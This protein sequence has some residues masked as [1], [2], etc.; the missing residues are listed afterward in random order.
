M[1]N[2]IVRIGTI[3]SNLDGIEPI[4]IPALFP[5]PR[6]TS[7]LIKASG[8][9]KDIAIAGVQ[10]LLLQ[11]LIAVPP[12]NLRFTFFDPLGLGQNI[13]SF[14]N[15]TEYDEM[16][17]NSRAWTEV[18]HIEQRLI[19]ISEHMENVIQ[20]YLR[21]EFATISEYNANAHE[22]AE[23]Y[24]ILVV[25][26]F[27]AN[28][29]EE[30]TRRLLSIAQNGPRCGVYAVIL[31][32]TEKELP[33]GVSLQELERV[34][35]VIEWRDTDFVWKDDLYKNF[36]LRLDTP[37]DNRLFN[38]ILYAVGEEARK[39]KEVKVPFSRIAPERENGQKKEQQKEKEPGIESCFS[40]PIGP[41]GARD[42]QKLE[43]GLG[44]GIHALVVGRTG[45]GKS[46][47]LHTI[48]VSLALKY[49]PDDAEL[50]LIDFKKG[51]EFKIYAEHKLPHARVIAIESEREFG[52][53]VLQGLDAEMQ[54]RG[55]LFRDNGVDSL[56]DYRTKVDRK[57][58]RILLLVDEFQEFFAEDDTVASQASQLLDRLVRQ[59]RA[60]GIHIL[61][62]SQTLAGAYA[63]SRS[64]IDQMSVRIALQC[65]D[66]DSRLILAD[67]NPA[68]RLL[69]R[70]GEA[71]YNSANGMIEGNNRFQ[72][73]WLPEEERNQYLE[74][75][76]HTDKSEE[77]LQIVFEGNIPAKL[78][79]NDIL[80]NLLKNGSPTTPQYPLRAYLGEPVAIS[81]PVS[82]NFRRQSGCN[83]LFVGRN[84]EEA[85]G[86]L[87]S[88]IVSLFAQLPLEDVT[89]DTDSVNTT[90]Y[91][92]D[93]TP[94]D[95]PDARFFKDVATSIPHTVK[96]GRRN[97]LQE[98]LTELETETQRR[99]DADEM[100]APAVFLLIFGLQ[101]ARDLRQ[102]NSFSPYTPEESEDTSPNPL[103][104]FETI[105]RD[106]PEVGVHTL[107]WCDTATNVSRSL[108]HDIMREFAMRVVM[109]MN[110]DDSSTLIDSPMASKLGAHRALFYDDEEIRL[111][112]L[113]PY[114][115]PSIEWLGKMKSV[116]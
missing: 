110:A 61:L 74:R 60:F 7:L 59:G 69:S 101:R 29:N 22:I 88:S 55:D 96:T 62:G 5:F 39:N 108:N 2:S 79:N 30:T 92:L 109:Q 34:T 8:D 86:M 18:R 11:L 115:T 75:I 41:K 46:T 56:Q 93:F 116:L 102:E 47:L 15:L 71:I 103:K 58:P 12:G 89:E 99:I 33:H 67:D 90:F 106:G 57:M 40:I 65:S 4:S 114:V 44:T 76:R 35:S 83:L 19:D 87:T 50:Y 68:A 97:Q 77:R 95:S 38:N 52:L 37:P 81:D 26:D 10:S 27:P 104:Q 20:K 25:F 64:T 105:L 85:R 72:V 111:E 84:E 78:E 113:R 51:V 16:L 73:A 48:I 66:A 14:M 94:A 107:V 1:I 24:R 45:S 112:K 70:P 91:I 49:S 32:D 36:V 54:K 23:P 98:Y 53:S 42:T 100:S 80:R 21:N 9:A 63:M 28:F 82:A 13:A 3:K 17:V 31:V 6:D 43:L